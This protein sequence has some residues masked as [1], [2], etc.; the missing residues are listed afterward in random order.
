MIC[1]EILGHFPMILIHKMAVSTIFSFDF[2][3]SA[4]GIKHLISIFIR[5]LEKWGT[6]LSP[7][8]KVGDIPPVSCLLTPMTA[9]LV[10][11]TQV[12]LAM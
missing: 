9:T 1:G 8:S 5:A 4:I 6:I 3:K 7:F 12:L 11:F 10:K 2:I